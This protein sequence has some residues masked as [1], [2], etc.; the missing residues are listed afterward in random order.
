MP[1]LVIL[2]SSTVQNKSVNIAFSW[3][4]CECR[5]MKTIVDSQNKYACSSK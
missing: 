3:Y 1:Q 4:A 5:I 2:F